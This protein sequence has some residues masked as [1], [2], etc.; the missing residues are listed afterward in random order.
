[1]SD[2][3]RDGK[4]D[5]A[6]PVADTIGEV[7]GAIVGAAAGTLVGMPAAGTIAGAVAGTL[8]ADGIAEL[9]NPEE[10][11]RYWRAQHREEPY[12]VEGS[13][14]DTL[15]APL[16]RLGWEARVK[17]HGL[18]FD[19]AEPEIRAEF[20]VLPGQ[21]MTW[22]EARPPVR[23]AWERVDERLRSFTRD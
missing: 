21:D 12:Y 18:V 3:R 17:Y 20:E 10:E 7:S 15:Y 13:S 1:M 5:P 2:E 16:Y 22:E 4:R 14:Y 6:H 8:A 9:V 23:A 19:D 11:D